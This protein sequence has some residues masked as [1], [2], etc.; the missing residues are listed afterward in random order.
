MF[1]SVA[2]EADSLVYMRKTGNR[3]PDWLMAGLSGKKER[4]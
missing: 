2:V 1:L 4:V 3:W